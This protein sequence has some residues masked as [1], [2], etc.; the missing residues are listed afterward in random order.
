MMSIGAWAKWIVLAGALILS[1]AACDAPAAVANE[2]A[3]P[4]TLAEGQAFW[5]RFGS[6]ESVPLP[7]ASE[8]GWDDQIWTAPEQGAQVQLADGSLVRLSPNARISVQRPYASDSRPVLRLLSGQVQVT[9]RSSGFFVETY[10][11][12]PLALHIALVNLILLPKETP[13]DFDL[14]F[15]QD[16]AKASVASG[17]V[18]VRAADVRGTLQVKWRAELAP[19]E[20]L[21]IISPTT[22]TPTA[23][24]TP[25]ASPTSLFTAT[26]T[27]TA[28]RTQT[29]VIRRSPTPSPASTTTPAVS[30][31]T[32][33]PVSNPGGGGGKPPPPPTNTPVPPTNTPPPRPPTNTPVPPTPTPRPV[34]TGGPEPTDTPASAGVIPTLP[35]PTIT[36]P[37]P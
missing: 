31:P 13:G 20:P 23:T 21:R 5:L 6:Q 1:L 27:P 36:L 19:G 32:D 28:T 18:D 8:M 9:A 14:L 33:T 11:E 15:E 24:W 30:P 4:I 34:P 29:P 3:L 16:T 2:N 35:L 10:R 22:P 37:L 25:R 7:A 17:A 26:A 12:V